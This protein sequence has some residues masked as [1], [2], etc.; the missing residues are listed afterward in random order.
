MVCSR[1]LQPTEERT[2]AC[3]F[4]LHRLQIDVIQAHLAGKPLIFQSPG[5]RI[6]FKFKIEKP[7]TFALE[8]ADLNLLVISQGIKEEFKVRCLNTQF[9]Y[10]Q[11]FIAYVIGLEMWLIQRSLFLLFPVSM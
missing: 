3:P 6:N 1:Y 7:N 4:D 10:T 8:G 11:A 2:G 9:P 5:D